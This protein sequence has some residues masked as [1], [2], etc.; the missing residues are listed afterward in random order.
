MVN[1]T[2]RFLAV[3]DPS[4][5][6]GAQH[7]RLPQ[8]AV[9]VL[10]PALAVDA[11]QRIRRMSRM[12]RLHSAA[13]ELEQVRRRRPQPVGLRDSLQDRHQ[14]CWYSCS[15]AKRNCRSKSE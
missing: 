10:V 5:E 3:L 2:S 14:N 11:V 9:Q 15:M 12:Q 4:A 6:T 1:N 8:A 7:L 13:E